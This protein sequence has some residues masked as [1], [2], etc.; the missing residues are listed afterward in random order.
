MSRHSM[1]LLAPLLY[2]GAAYAASRRPMDAVVPLSNGVSLSSLWAARKAGPPAT[3]PAMLLAGG[4]V[5]SDLSDGSKEH[6]M[7]RLLTAAGGGTLGAAAGL[8]LADM[9]PKEQRPLAA[10]LTAALGAGLG[11]KMG[12]EK[13][14]NIL[15]TVAA[16]FRRVVTT[17]VQNA[18]AANAAKAVGAA[19]GTAARAVSASVP[20]AEQA[21]VRAAAPAAAA[22]AAAA[23]RQVAYN[24]GAAPAGAFTYNVGR[25]VTQVA[26]NF[27]PPPRQMELFPGMP[28]AAPAAPVAAPAAQSAPRIAQPKVTYVTPGQQTPAAQAQPAAMANAQATQ[29]QATQNL[30]TA[31]QQAAVQQAVQGQPL[32]TYDA[33]AQAE[34][35]Q[36]AA[37]AAAKGQ[38]GGFGL[39]S[40]L[41][42][43][44][45]AGMIAMPFLQGGDSMHEQAAQS[46]A[47]PGYAPGYPTY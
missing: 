20:A 23:G 29:Q 9:L 16:P 17:A 24:Y 44:L 35:A 19:E 39:G 1:D 5:A 42:L 22:P 27:R 6:A 11:T 8:H 32:Y 37:N 10:A 26:P 25:G 46:Y 7:R 28:A 36:Q 21:A 31:E 13:Q 18:Q 2:G 12:S 30:A 14:A 34:A 33:A 15:R 41:G 45:P 4:A 43:A 47:P 3:V 40:L 38:G